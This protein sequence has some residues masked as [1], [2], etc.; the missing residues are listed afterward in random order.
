MK[1]LVA[2]AMVTALAGARAV[3]PD[4]FCNTKRLA[5]EFAGD[6]LPERAGTPGGLDVIALGLGVDPVT[7]NCT[8]PSPNPP[9]APPPP[10]PV[11]PA[12]TCSAP[13]PGMS[14]VYGDHTP[15]S[16]HPKTADAASCEALC[17]ANHSCTY[18]TWH[19][20]HQG[21]YANR[22]LLR[23]DSMYNPHRQ[24]G[25]TSFLCNMTGQVSRIPTAPDGTIGWAPENRDLSSLPPRHRA[26]RA[27]VPMVAGVADSTYFVDAIKG[28]DSNSGTQDS[29]LKTIAAGVAKA[30]SGGTVYLRQGTFYLS[31]TVS[32]PSGVTI[33]AYQKEEVVVSGGVQLTPTWSKVSSNATA[34]IDIY[35]ASVPQGMS[36][37]ELFNGSNARLVPARNPNGN[38]ELAP[39]ESKYSFSGKETSCKDFGPATTVIVNNTCP[40]C[41]DNSKGMFS[42]YSMGLGGPANNF[43]PAMSYWAQPHPHG[44]GAN[45]Y[46]IPNGVATSDSTLLESGGGGYVFMMQTHH[47]GSW[48]YEIADV[49]NNG[50]NITFGA[51]GFQEARGGSGG[52]GT[53]SFYIS[54]RKELLDYPG[55]W[56]L[57]EAESK[58]YT[59]VATAGVPPATV[60]A[61]QIETLFK[62][63]GTQE[64][65]V[66]NARVSSL[67]L[68]HAAPT[69]MANYSVGSGGDYSVHR[70]GAVL[71][72]GTENVTIDHNLFDGVGGNGVWLHAYNRYASVTANEMRNIGE[73]GVGFTGETVW[74]DGTGGNQP[75]FNTITGNVIHHLGLYTK[76]AC[77]VFSAVACQNLIEENVFFHGPRALFN[78][79][80]DF[81]GDTM[82][83]RNLFFKSLLETSDHGPY[84]SWDRLPYLTKV[85]NGTA[86][87]DSAY[88]HLEA[89]LFFSGSP[90]SIDTDDG[91]DLVNCTSNV[92][93]SQPLFKTDFSGHT[94]TFQNNVDLYGS[95]GASE[96]GGRDPTNVFTGNKCV[97]DGTP[98]ACG[99]CATPG[100]TCPLIQNNEYY[101]APAGSAPKTLCPAGSLEA[102]SQVLPVPADGGIGLARAALGMK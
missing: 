7:K 94:K 90:F 88:N 40:G 32:V 28:S 89:N 69:Y 41:V 25:H 99:T 5:L 83:R 26:W 100:V 53:G 36:F 67:T 72:V 81:G 57:D 48:V 77:A 80:D 62:A 63:V 13:M 101:T 58:L 17:K 38:A 49:T 43:V 96:P 54:H 31:E 35:A 18:G 95:C 44:G 61:P 78:M 4:V 97:G 20:E 2:M 34:G 24:D 60:Y 1:G 10:K 16:S 50:Q 22:C 12:G 74:V 84:N 30:A 79:N 3:D 15:V 29:P 64:A 33:S 42:Y 27:G 73:N 87:I 92:I 56:Y 75:R 6:I 21:P 23:T 52:C 93:V 9:P 91:S 59:V 47:W 51:G 46:D 37:L 85:K 19:D 39:E 82:I 70:G 86:T 71:L 76:Q 65:P 45:T 98:L 8:G 68:R 14:L 55:E 66:K 11:V 102:N